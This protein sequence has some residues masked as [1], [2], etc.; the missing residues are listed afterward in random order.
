[1]YGLIKRQGTLEQVG[2]FLRSRDLPHSGNSWTQMVENRLKVAV[3]EKKLSDLDLLEL[4]RQT[5]EHGSQHIFLYTLI[6]GRKIDKLFNGDFPKILSTAKFP[7][8]GTVSLVDMPEKPTIVEVRTDVVDGVKSVVFKIVEKRSTLDKVSDTTK[9]GQFI[10]TYNEVPYRAVNV[11]RIIEDGR[12]EIR[13]QSH[14]D[15]ISYSGIA[16]SIFTILDGVV[17][18]LDWKDDKLDKFKEALLDEKRRKAIMSRFGL[19]HTQHTNTDGTRLTAAAGFPGASMYDDTDAVAS[20][21]RFLAKKGHAHCDKASVT[22]RKGA[23]L[24]RDVGLIVG[25][26]A[27]EFA[28]TSKV[29]RAE[30]ETILRTVIEFNV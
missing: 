8:L 3:A 13:L 16:S 5:E 25:G 21:D 17:N 28:I 23:G 6:P 26:E 22:V 24:K 2:N 18:R 1:M 29:S 19:R 30:Y 20:V 12:A 4:L 7:A 9:N 11:M 15:S 14:S 10:V 27:N